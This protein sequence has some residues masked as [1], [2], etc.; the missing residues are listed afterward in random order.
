MAVL[1]IPL[2][3]SFT[4]LGLSS[5]TIVLRNTIPNKYYLRT[6]NVCID[7]SLVGEMIITPVPFL[8]LVHSSSQ[9]HSFAKKFVLHAH[10]FSNFFTVES[11]SYKKLKNF[12][13][14]WNNGKTFSLL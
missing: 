4:L 1:L 2:V 13:V 7:S 9:F 14:K 3:Q 8:T 12:V 11:S 6:P 5:I 10:T